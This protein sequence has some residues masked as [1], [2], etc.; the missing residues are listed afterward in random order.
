MEKFREILKE[1]IDEKGAK[2]TTICKENGI[3]SALIYDYLNGFLYPSV[4]TLIKLAIYF[5]CSLD[6]ML[7]L[8]DI[9]NDKKYVNIHGDVSLFLPRYFQLLKDNHTTHYL[10]A[11]EHR[12][13]ESVIRNWKKGSVPSL[14]KLKL[15]AYEL[16]SSVDYLVGRT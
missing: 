13:G 14:E 12:F 8:T 9:K 3:P 4:Q 1:L 15:I 6:Y 2:I 10:F 5:D 16:G 11:Q 7:N